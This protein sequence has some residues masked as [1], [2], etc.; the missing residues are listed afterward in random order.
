MKPNLKKTVSDFGGDSVL[1]QNLSTL[2]LASRSSDLGLRL[3]RFVTSS[4]SGKLRR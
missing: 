2:V 4:T 1:E 3:E